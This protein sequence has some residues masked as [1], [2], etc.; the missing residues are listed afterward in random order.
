MSDREIMRGTL[1]LNA[2]E[3]EAWERFVGIAH[4]GGRSEDEAQELMARASRLALL[5]CAE[6]AGG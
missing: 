3:R 1:F 2:Q 4:E 5:H 6:R